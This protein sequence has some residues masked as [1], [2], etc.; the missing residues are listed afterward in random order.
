[1]TKETNVL[2]KDKYRDYTIVVRLAG[3]IIVT[4][5]DKKHKTAF[6]PIIFDNGVEG[7]ELVMRI[8]S[9]ELSMTDLREFTKEVST[10]QKAL[11]YF[12]KKLYI[13]GLTDEAF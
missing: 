7:V 13:K 9:V 5:V 6:T 2:Y 8:G 3:N 4:E 10:A 12:N 11:E 1:M